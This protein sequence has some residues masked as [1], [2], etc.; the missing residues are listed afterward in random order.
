MLLFVQIIFV[1][2]FISYSNKKQQKIIK[3]IYKINDIKRIQ[4]Y[5]S[6]NFYSQLL[7]TKK[8]KYLFME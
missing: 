5:L 7:Q 3:T 2:C 6:S 8:L 4:L 1:I